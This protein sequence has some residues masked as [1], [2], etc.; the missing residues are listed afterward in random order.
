MDASVEILVPEHAAAKVKDAL[1]PM[2]RTRFA[3]TPSGRSTSSVLV[4][5][6]ADL[7]SVT[8]LRDLEARWAVASKGARR[9]PVILLSWGRRT[10]YG[11]EVFQ[12][13]FHWSR[14]TAQE[15]YVAPDAAA[16]RRIVLARQG[17]AEKELV[18]SA[19]IEGGKL[20]VWSCE[21]SRYE[22]PVAELA[23]LAGMAP[24][25]LMRFEVSPS[26]S[27]IHWSDADVDINL[28]TIREHADPSVRR[29]HEAVAR[30]EASRYADAIRRFREERGLKQTDISGLTDRQ[31]RRLED[32]DTVPQ[33]GTLRKL[34]AA[35]G[36]SIEDYLSELAK[37]SRSRPARKRPQPRRRR[38]T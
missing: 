14:R 12:G 25:A 3:T 9:V 32:G 2:R 30:E 21:P 36:L 24:G 11:G 35:H 33:V 28:D 8:G 7:D 27:R 23:P 34:A 1:G 18:A 38:A 19:S 37:R 29:E 13:L 10:T 26:G 15:P 4:S 16:L 17:N 5:W 6:L 20:V 31:V 22:V